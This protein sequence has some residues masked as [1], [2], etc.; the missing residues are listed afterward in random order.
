MPSTDHTRRTGPT[1]RRVLAYGS[2]T[3]LGGLAFGTT[4]GSAARSNEPNELSSTVR[5]VMVPY[6]YVPD[7]RCRIV[8]R[9]LD[10]RPEPL[11]D[12]YRTHV[13]AYEHAPSLRARYVTDDALAAADAVELE[14][15]APD[16]SSPSGPSLVGVA[17]TPEA[18]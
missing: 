11:D 14:R 16:E 2:L 12:R 9:D 3:A 13:L 8:E 6:Q 17:A 18:R 10:W 4:A 1:R 5:G 15:V 7:S